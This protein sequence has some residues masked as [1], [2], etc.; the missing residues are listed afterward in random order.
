[1][2]LFKVTD[3]INIP[4]NAKEMVI[5]AKTADEALS[6]ANKFVKDF[7]DDG[8]SWTEPYQGDL[9]VEEIS[10]SGPAELVLYTT[11]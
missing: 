10:L 9:V 1:M 11:V 4:Y 3:K 8:C 7:N 2:K 6:I 5:R